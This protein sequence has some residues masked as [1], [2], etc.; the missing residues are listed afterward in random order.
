MATG[1]NIT[2]LQEIV[3]AFDVADS[4]TDDISTVSN[5]NANPQSPLFVHMGQPERAETPAVRIGEVPELRAGE[6]EQHDAEMAE[7]RVDVG[8]RRIGAILRLMAGEYGASRL[9]DIGRRVARLIEAQGS[10]GNLH[11]EIDDPVLRYAVLELIKGSFLRDGA[12]EAKKVVDT[13]LDTLYRGAGRQIRASINTAEA[14]FAFS[15]EPKSR[16]EFRRLYYEAIDLDAPL[17]AKLIFNGITS[18]VNVDDIDRVIGA[19]SEALRADVLAART[20]VPRDHLARMLSYL[21]LF[22]SARVAQTMV[23]FAREL[24]N[25]MGVCMIDPNIKSAQSDNRELRNGEDLSLT[26]ELF[27]LG[28]S[29]VP[30]TLMDKLADSVVGKEAQHR[31]RFFTVLYRQS[32]QWPLQVWA[33]DE[34]R[35]VVH[36]QLHRRM[37]QLFN[38]RQHVL[39]RAISATVSA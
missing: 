33:S 31:S 17:T 10:V 18:V 19:M 13:E 25:E 38:V 23:S 9:L 24:L 4:A 2:A 1:S 35:N 26:K 27:N 30:G 21:D 22:S 5:L 3:K 20:S 36:T 6:K 37:D 29:T 8:V 28:T 12:S 39:S 16:A 7:E 11:S 32:C 14:A 15:S 34:V